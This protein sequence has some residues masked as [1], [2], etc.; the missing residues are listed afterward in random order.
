MIAN[1]PYPPSSLATRTGHMAPPARSLGMRAILLHGPLVVLAGFYTRKRVTTTQCDLREQGGSGQWPGGRGRTALLSGAG[2][3]SRDRSRARTGMRRRRTRRR[4]TGR[5]RGRRPRPVGR[6]PS[7]GWR[8][9]RRGCRRWWRGRR[10]AGPVRRRGGGEAPGAAGAEGWRG[11]LGGRGPGRGRPPG[12][13]GRPEAGPGRWRHRR[14]SAGRGPGAGRRPG[15]RRCGDQVG[16]GPGDGQGGAEATAELGQGGRL[17]VEL[18]GQHRRA[19]GVAIRAEGPQPHLRVG[20]QQPRPDRPRLRRQA[21]G[22]ARPR[23]RHPTGQAPGRPQQ[24]HQGINNE[25][26]RRLAASPGHRSGL[27][28][29]PGQRLAKLGSA[30]K[31]LGVGK[32]R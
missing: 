30:S 22:A 11:P 15:R 13:A 25:H 21:A 29:A 31:A 24:P 19:E 7:G 26:A 9:R 12:R 8:P 18:A 27:S 4:R 16:P 23:H 10:P 20:G 17:A 5:R 1:R 32:V 2:R 14:R 28:T 3:A 6:R